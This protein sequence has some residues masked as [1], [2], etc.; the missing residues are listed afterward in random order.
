MGELPPT[1]TPEVQKVLGDAMWKAGVAASDE[2]LAKA[3]KLAAE[4]YAAEPEED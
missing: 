2:A 4:I 1:P 3:G